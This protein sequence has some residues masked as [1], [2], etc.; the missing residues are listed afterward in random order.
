NEGYNPVWLLLWISA[1][2]ANSHNVYNQRISQF[3]GS[4][5]R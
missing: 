4:P 2:D 3:I 1:T 5:Q